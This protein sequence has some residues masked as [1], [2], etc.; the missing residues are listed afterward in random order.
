MAKHKV[1]S[2]LKYAVEYNGRLD[3]S[4]VDSVVAALYGENDGAQWYWVLKMKDGTH[5]L[6]VGGCDYTGW[7]CRSWFDF[8]PTKTALQAAKLAPAKEDDYSST[9]RVQAVLTK[10]IKGTQPFGSI[11]SEDY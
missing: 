5:G 4:K 6:G 2:D 3:L 11:N 10:Q 9:R 1:D 7:D 8:T